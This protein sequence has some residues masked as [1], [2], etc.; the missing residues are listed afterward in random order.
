MRF[1][2]GGVLATP[3]RGGRALPVWFRFEVFREW[4]DHGIDDTLGRM[5]EASTNETG[6]PRTYS[7]L[8]AG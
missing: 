3:R 4:I 1:L 5:W 2:D 8:D 6:I 7:Q